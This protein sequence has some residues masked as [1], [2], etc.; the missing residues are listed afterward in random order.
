MNA[1]FLSEDSLLDNK[2]LIAPT[3]KEWLIQAI[4][5]PIELL[6]D[7][8]HCERK[9]AGFAM[10]L[11]FRYLSEPGLSEVLS[12]LIREELEHYERVVRLLKRRGRTLFPLAAPPYGA[13][14][15]K[16]V[17]KS[18]PRRMLDSFLVAGLIEARSHERM[19]LLSKHSPEKDLRNLYSDLLASEEKHASIYWKLAKDRY[20][21]EIVRARL[22]TLSENESEIL[23]KLHPYPRM[24]S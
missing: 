24:H 21:L 4:S 1:I 11:M 18:E 16:I 10:Q 23:S 14:L 15:A 19:S 2:W 9:A 12:P 7:H 13:A 5:N 8:A 20:E 17:R 3:R 6:V 22:K